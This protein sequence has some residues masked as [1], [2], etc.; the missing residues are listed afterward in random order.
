MQVVKHQFPGDPPAEVAIM[1][2]REFKRLY[3]RP[4]LHDEEI[5]YARGRV[6]FVA[7]PD[8]DEIVCDSCNRDIGDEVYV[9]R[10]ERLGQCS[11][12]DRGYC[13]DCYRKELVPYCEDVQGQQPR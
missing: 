11:G 6:D 9:Y 12:S 3:P 4:T 13:E 1:S 8:A 7:M 2:R 10:Y 5:A